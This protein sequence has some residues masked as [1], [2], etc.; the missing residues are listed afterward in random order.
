MQTGL[1]GKIFLTTGAVNEIGR[2]TAIW[3][4]RAIAKVARLTPMQRRFKH[5]PMRS[6]RCGSRL[7]HRV[8]S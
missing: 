8:G 4:L 2:A 3:R 1:I 7:D 5:L 6:A